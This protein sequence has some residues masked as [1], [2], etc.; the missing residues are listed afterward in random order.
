MIRRQPRTKRTYTRFRFTT[1]LRSRA[2]DKETATLFFLTE[3][4]GAI[5][6]KAVVMRDGGIRRGS[7][8]LKAMALGAKAVLIGRPGMFALSYGEDGVRQMLEI[9]CAELRGASQGIGCEDVPMQIVRESCRDRG[10][11]EVVIKVGAVNI[12]KTNIQ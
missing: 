11:E 4:V 10:C 9:L 3:I 6:S 12:K 7:A 2:L 8:V 1:L 5:G